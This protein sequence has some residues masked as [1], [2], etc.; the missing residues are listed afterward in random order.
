M[1][2][3]E[4]LERAFGERLFL[5]GAR[6]ASSKCAAV[7]RPYPPGVHGPGKRSR[8]TSFG[9]Q[10]REKQKAKIIYGLPERQFRKYFDKATGRTGNTGEILITMLEMRL[11][12]V[13]Y[14]LGIAPSRRAARQVVSHGHITLNGKKVDV[15]SAQVRAGD[16][17]GIRAQSQGKKYFETIRE[18]FAKQTPVWLAPNPDALTAKVIG[19]P[20]GD[21]LKQNFDPK[22]II[23]F[24]SR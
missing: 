16:E 5:K 19:V 21:D 1:G 22:P 7:R 14:R 12:N 3:R 13:A 17:I 18:T 20:A 2:A 24:Y 8:P 15:P 6:C 10:L 23:E 11:D 4:K 9:T